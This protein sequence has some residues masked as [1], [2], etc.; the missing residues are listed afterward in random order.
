M[1][2]TYQTKNDDINLE[3]ENRINSLTYENVIIF[4]MYFIK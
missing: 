2:S 4:Q 3:R 1:L